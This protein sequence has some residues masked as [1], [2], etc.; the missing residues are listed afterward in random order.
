MTRFN[1]L[2]GLMPCLAHPLFSR[3]SAAQRVHPMSGGLNRVRIDAVSDYRALRKHQF[4]VDEVPLPKSLHL[5]RADAD[6]N[7]RVK[8]EI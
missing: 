2:T 8:I 7:R 3:F 5:S 4:D 1:T 6:L